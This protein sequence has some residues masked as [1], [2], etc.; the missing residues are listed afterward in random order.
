[1]WLVIMFTGYFTTFKEWDIRTC[2]PTQKVL[3]S[4][5]PVVIRTVLIKWIR[6]YEYLCWGSNPNSMQGNLLCNGMDS[7][8]IKKSLYHLIIF[9]LITN[10]GKC[11]VKDG[12]IRYIHS[13]CK[14]KSL[15]QR[16]KRPRA[17]PLHDDISYHEVSQNLKGGGLLL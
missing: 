14:V 12:Q 17:G 16:I 8:K 7:L 3:F 15:P 11:L 2:Y 9:C 1:M 4:N 13:L 5:L 6:F 10:R